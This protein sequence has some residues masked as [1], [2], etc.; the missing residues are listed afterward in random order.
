MAVNKVRIN[1]DVRLKDRLVAIN[2]LLRLQRVLEP[3][4]SQPLLSLVMKT[5]LLDRA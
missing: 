1:S 4:V 2:Q 5:A 3:L